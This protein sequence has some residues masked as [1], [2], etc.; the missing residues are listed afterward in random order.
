MA[1][2]FSNSWMCSSL[3]ELSITEGCSIWGLSIPD[4]VS[5][6]DCPLLTIFPL[7]TTHY[8]QCS[9]WGLPVT[10]GVSSGDSPL[11]MVFPLGTAHYWQCC[12]W[13]LSITN[14]DAL[15]N[16]PSLK[17]FPLG[18]IYHWRSL[19]GEFPL[20]ICQSFSYQWTASC[21][22]DTLLESLHILYIKT[23]SSG[24]SSK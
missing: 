12:L 4:G 22:T 24:Q 23:I 13:G 20:N 7:G 6:E 3:W 19:L 11:L 15:G 18:I 5:S 1:S 17:A 10:D 8:W 16:Y 14:G 21:W 9:L 2:N